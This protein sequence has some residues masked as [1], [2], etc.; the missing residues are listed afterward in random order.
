V[1]GAPGE[2]PLGVCGLA[3]PGLTVPG[4]VGLLPPLVPVPV[5]GL[6]LPGEVVP[7]PGRPA[8]VPLPAP[9]LPEPVLLPVPPGLVPS[10]AAPEP[11]AWAK[12]EMGRASATRAVRAWKGRVVFI[13]ATVSGGCGESRVGRDPERTPEPVHC[14]AGK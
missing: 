6:V 10:L 12:A 11:P 14:H 7:V 5:A 13:D 4:M 8:P 3:V 9:E 1:P 2:V